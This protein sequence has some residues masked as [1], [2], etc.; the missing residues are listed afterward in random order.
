[1]N[2]PTADAGLVRQLLPEGHGD[3]LGRAQLPG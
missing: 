2:Y 3:P 1:V